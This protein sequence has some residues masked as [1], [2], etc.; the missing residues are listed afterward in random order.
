MGI[1]DGAPRR[2]ISLFLQPRRVEGKPALGY[3]GQLADKVKEIDL[4]LLPIPLA[5][6][7]AFFQ[8]IH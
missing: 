7:A 2:D 1:D 8:N 5:D 6:V 4:F 3:A